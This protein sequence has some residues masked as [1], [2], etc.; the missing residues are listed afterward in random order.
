[1]PKV[2]YRAKRSRRKFNKSKEI[3]AE[4]AA[5]MDATVKPHFIKA[6]ERVV[7]N[8][9]HKPEF[10]ARKYVRAN[11]IAVYVFPAGQY[12]KIW[13]YV[14]AGTKG[15]YKIPKTGPGY[16]AFQIGYKPKTK[17][18]GKFGGPGVA[19]GPWIRGVMQ[20]EHPGIKAREF[21]KTIADDERDWYSREMENAWRR[22]LR[23][24]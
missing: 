15:P 23:A 10:K 22:T 16:L 17:P 5:F 3:Q 13:K 21:E 6:F 2:A 9:E 19:T 11:S 7:C 4:M 12:K 1:M 24:V 20:V 14:S 8:W 18:P